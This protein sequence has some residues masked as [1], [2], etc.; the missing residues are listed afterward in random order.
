MNN[1]DI[2]DKV[3]RDIV[4]WEDFQRYRELNVRLSPKAVDF[5]CTLVDNME[6]DSSQIWRKGNFNNSQEYAI[7]LIPNAL[8][9]LLI[10]NRRLGKKN[11]ETLITTWEIW[12]SLSRLIDVFC[13]VPKDI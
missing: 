12:H 2:R 10:R 13:F 11:V 1:V 7:Q 9:E 4:K 8:N 3:Q 5:L 6:T